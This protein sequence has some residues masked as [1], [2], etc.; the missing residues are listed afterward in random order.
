MAEVCVIGRS[1]RLRHITQNEALIV[2]HILRKPNS[3]I[4][5]LFIRICEPFP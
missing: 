1:R 5:L 2:P 4:V 3:I